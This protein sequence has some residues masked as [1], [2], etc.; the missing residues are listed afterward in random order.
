MELNE[1]YPAPADLVESET[2]VLEYLRNQPY[3]KEVQPTFARD[4]GQYYEQNR[5]NKA[6]F[7]FFSSLD[8]W[9]AAMTGQ[10]WMDPRN[11]NRRP[12]LRLV[13]A[14]RIERLGR[15]AYGNVTYCIAVLKIRRQDD[16]AILR[17]FHFDIA[18][19]GVSPQGRRQRHPR[20]HVQY[21]GKM[22]PKMQQM[23][24]RQSQLDQ[25]HP[26]LSEPRIF[27][28]PMSLGLLIDMAFHEFPDPRSAKFRQ[29]PSWRVLIHEQQQ[30]VLLPFHKKCSE[31]IAS[32]QRLTDEFYVG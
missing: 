14:T 2:R 20:C 11:E 9:H 6:G 30:L 21:C 3:I 12:N 18:C 16:Y 10:I 23:G 13:I 5:V 24:C 7:E 17:K 29:D 28:S 8:I 31:I 1:F 25:M 4:A 19:D 32:Q 15:K 26:G 27:C 22:L